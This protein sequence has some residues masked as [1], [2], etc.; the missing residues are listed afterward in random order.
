MIPE[1][2]STIVTN[3]QAVIPSSD[4]L[5][6][7]LVILTEVLCK[8]TTDLGRRWRQERKRGHIETS[9]SCIPTLSEIA[10]SEALRALVVNILATP[11]GEKVCKDIFNTIRQKRAYGSLMACT[12]TSKAGKKCTY[13]TR[14]FFCSPKDRTNFKCPMCKPK[15]K[16]NS[17]RRLQPGGYNICPVCR[18]FTLYTGRN[19]VNGE[20][21]Y[22]KTK[23]FV[24]AKEKHI[25]IVRQM[26]AKLP[27][28][29]YIGFLCSNNSYHHLLEPLTKGS[30]LFD[31][32]NGD[33]SRVMPPKF[34]AL[35]RRDYL[36]EC[37]AH[38]FYEYI[39]SRKNI[40]KTVLK[41]A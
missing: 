10:A 36:V 15:C 39:F 24:C 38:S 25:G 23:C 2:L 41:F 9:L 6:P 1:I 26:A 37:L 31:V 7:E 35:T 22:E 28:K 19:I 12:G 11:H 5:L 3:M 20:Q 14:V 21:S 30:T 18:G 13:M 40:V 4:E 27:V 34:D 29:T 17:L 32:L 8:N 33:E 16:V